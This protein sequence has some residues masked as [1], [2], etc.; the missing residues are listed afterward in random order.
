MGCL[1]SKPKHNLE[2]PGK[3]I[4]YKTENGI[5]KEQFAYIENMYQGTYYYS[6]GLIGHH[7][8]HCTRNQIRELTSDEIEIINQGYNT[9]LPH[10]FYDS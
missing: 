6:Y 5:K 3:Y 7:E 9:R 2:I 4:I 10:Q 1:F 8:G